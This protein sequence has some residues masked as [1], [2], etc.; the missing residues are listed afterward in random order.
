[1]DISEKKR[2]I[3]GITNEVKELHP[4]LE[5]VLPKLKGVKSYEY[6][7]GQYER[8]AD[9][10]IQ[11]EN[12]TT[13]RTSHVGVVVKCG[14]VS[15]AK[16]S[17][18][19]EQIKECAEERAY[20]VMNRVRCT[21]VWVFASDGYSERAKEKLL[22][23]LTG[24]RIEF[25]GPEDIAAFVD[26]HYPYFWS[27]LP[28]AIGNYLQGTKA[29]LEA[30][31]KTTA[32]LISAVHSET[33]IELDTYEHSKK[34]YT[35]SNTSKPS[36]KS[37]DFLKEACATSFGLLEAEMG[38]GKSKLARRLALSLCDAESFKR[39][40]LLPVFTTYRH[41]VDNHNSSL[42][43]LTKS[44]LGGAY[45]IFE[46]GG[47]EVL[48]ILDG[49]DECSS[50]GT[51]TTDL[52]ERLRASFGK[53]NSY[54]V[55]VTSRP[56][57]SLVDRAALYADTRTFG[58]RPLS[59]AKIVRYL[60]QTCSNKHLPSRLFEDLKRS[61]LFKQLPQSPIAAT[62]FSNLLA[63]SHQEVPQSLTELYSKSLELMLGR[64]DQNKSLATEKQFKT[65]QLIAEHIA[66]YYLENQIIFVAKDEFSKLIDEYLLKRNTGIDSAQVHAILIERSNV[67]V[68][69]EDAGTI[70]FRHRSFA[71]FL[72]ASKRAKDRS[73]KVRDT[74]LNPYWINVFY[75]Y[76]GTLLD[77]PEVLTE[78]QQ[79]TGNTETEE[80]MKLISVPS[81]LLAAYQT[82]FDA[83][84]S[85]LKV[86]LLDA[87]RLFARVKEGDTRTRLKDLSEMHL[88]YLFKSVV[89]ESLGY[90][91]FNRGFESVA[92][93][94]ADELDDEEVKAHAL[95][96][97]SCAALHC[98]NDACFKF[99]IDSIGASKLPIAISLAIRCELE[100][101]SS[102]Q[103]SKLLK[104][105]KDKLRK[106]LLGG[107]RKIDPTARL[108]T[109]ARLD[110]LF[111]KPLSTRT[112]VSRLPHIKARHAGARVKP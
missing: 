38:F 89:V 96:F 71:E 102:I 6:T 93:Q 65:A 88:L 49:I 70:A 34:T 95:F 23:R 4:I 83:V 98:G 94:I 39:R 69:D 22:D 62:L 26:D 61:P 57:K 78:L 52:F 90:E 87:A 76:V 8:G 47:F 105:H 51:T 5:N 24:R 12:P 64:W 2:R 106:A 46:K 29:K 112:N 28:A 55:I 110:E 33:Y 75:F 35:N 43:D 50:P 72:C 60:E 3:E 36:V 109:Q 14:K 107:S 31:D 68:L 41:F 1:M 80:W 81:Y 45:D 74:A 108:A 66:C 19:E 111:E 21:E 100:S 103:N 15:G 92:L 44:A 25:F 56:L 82:E 17:D 40:K 79:T 77:C 10:I 84:E 27:D 54:R 32:L 42:E 9:F 11:V 85:N 97:L 63:Q 104:S 18:V 13:K 101:V 37:V 73:I 58:I 67:F 86:A 99:M 20:Q 91:F 7:H 48:V 53:L 59:L 30:L 16:A